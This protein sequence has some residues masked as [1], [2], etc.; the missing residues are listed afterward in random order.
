MKRIVRHM[1]WL[2]LDADQEDPWLAEDPASSIAK[3]VEHRRPWFKLIHG[4]I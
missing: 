3:L 2:D 1:L 4:N